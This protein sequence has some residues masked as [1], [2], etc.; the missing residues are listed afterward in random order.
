MA[1][2]DD[3]V[4]KPIRYLCSICNAVSRELRPVFPTSA[5]YE[6]PEGWE[7]RHGA[8]AFVWVC[9]ECAKK[10]CDDRTGK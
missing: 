7:L 6:V 1:G 8:C 5:I 2:K 9:V 4:D 10:S 3:L